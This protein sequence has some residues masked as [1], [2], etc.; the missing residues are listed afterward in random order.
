MEG[1]ILLAIL[2][3]GAAPDPNRDFAKHR[4]MATKAGNGRGGIF[5]FEGGDGGG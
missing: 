3:T 4:L 1:L 2:L 5:F